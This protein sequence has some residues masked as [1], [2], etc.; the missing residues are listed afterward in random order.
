MVNSFL[1]GEWLYENIKSGHGDLLSKYALLGDGNYI[2]GELEEE[3]RSIDAYLQRNPQYKRYDFISEGDSP[4]FLYLINN[5][6]RSLENPAYG[7]W[8]GRFG[9]DAHNV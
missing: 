6:L 8:G 9:K 3:Q 2:E 5:G 1:Q 7:S 4:S